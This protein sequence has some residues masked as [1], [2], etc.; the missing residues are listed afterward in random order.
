M[1]V[2]RED[3]RPLEAR[4]GTAAGVLVIELVVTPELLAEAPPAARVRLLGA[5]SPQALRTTDGRPL[6][7][8]VTLRWPLLPRLHGSGGAP[9]LLSVNGRPL[10]LSATL[11]TAGPL[12]L[13]FDGVLDPATVSPEACPLWPREGEITLKTPL[14]PPVSWRLVGERFELLLDLGAARGSYWLQLG[15]VGVR[16]LAGHAPEPPLKLKI[17]VRAS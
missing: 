2:E 10:P 15:T 12:S 6:A 14:E 9:R 11:E 3:G 13:L 7:A 8:P 4:L 16:G 17:E 5:P 1:T